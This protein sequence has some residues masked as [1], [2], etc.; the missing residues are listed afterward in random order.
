MNKPFIQLRRL[1]FTG[2]AVPSASVSF[3][4]GVNLIWGASNTGKSFAL[5][6]I[7]F[8]LGGSTALPNISER[9]N[10]DRIFLSF[11]ISN[12]DEFTFSRAASGGTF[13]LHSGIV[14]DCTINVVKTL[15][16]SHSAENPDTVS[17]F[18]LSKIDFGKRLVAKNAFGATNNLSFRNIAKVILADEGAIQETRSPIEG[19]Q[20]METTVERS[21]FRLLLSG[22]D[23]SALTPGKTSS[24]ATKSRTYKLELVNELI[25]ETEAELASDFPDSAGYPEQEKKLSSTIQKHESEFDVARTSVFELLE[26]K[27]ILS[28]KIPKANGRLSE[29]NLHIGRFE[30]LAEIYASDV[31][32]LKAIEEAGFLVSMISSRPCS[33]CG[34]EPGAQKHSH[35]AENAQATIKASLA[36]IAKIERLQKD[37]KLTVD[38]LFLESKK[39]SEDVPRLQAELAN[40]EQ[41]IAAL[42]PTVDA[43]RTSIAEMRNLRERLLR[44]IH[45]MNQLSSYKAKKEEVESERGTPKKDQPTL[46][47]EPSLAHEFCLEVAEVLKRWKFPGPCVVSFDKE[48]Y[49]LQI[50]GKP[51]GSNGKGVRAITH[52]AFKVALLLFCR[53]HELPHPG[54]LVLDTPLLTYRDPITNAR[55]GQLAADEIALSKTALK[56]SFFEHLKSIENLGQFIVFENVDPPANAESL[57]QLIPFTGSNNGRRGFFP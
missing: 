20:N 10:Y 36:E 25:S 11:S 4:A 48:T 24:E 46:D 29:I 37:L 45:L 49:D 1:E 40:V 33:L 28:V 19:G 53:K 42:F 52:A 51:R 31:E 13:T 3:D 8:M 56:Q 21:V 9:R 44:G 32:R 55:A 18:L 23:D 5:Q 12:G 43:S 15:G 26:L 22:L 14:N 2:P 54:F 16:A 30:K 50:D 47:L 38:S 41:K 27:K 17:G 39:L 57:A 6:A 34:A 35:T 7:D